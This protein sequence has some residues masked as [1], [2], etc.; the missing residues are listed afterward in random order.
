M[1]Y[2]CIGQIQKDLKK[3]TDLSASGVDGLV[4]GST[5]EVAVHR[6]QNFGRSRVRGHLGPSADGSLAAPRCVRAKCMYTKA[7]C[8]ARAES[9]AWLGS[10]TRPVAIRELSAGECFTAG[11]PPARWRA[12]GSLN[13]MGG[14]KRCCSGPVLVRGA[15]TVDGR[16][17]RDDEGDA[18]IMVDAPR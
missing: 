13:F 5:P 17:R 11:A 6:S 4:P 7:G 8:A 12:E 18:R 16:G 14:P 15:G 3:S 10:G 9:R 1:R 2:L